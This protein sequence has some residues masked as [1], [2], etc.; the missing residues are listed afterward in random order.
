MYRDYANADAHVPGFYR[1]N[2]ERQTLEFARAK[3][4]RYGALNT[5]RMGIWGACETLDSL[6]DES[7]PDT[8]L[9]QIEHCLQTAEGIRRDGHPDGFVL[10]GLL[11]DLG[12]ILC[13]GCDGSA[14]STNTI[15]IPST[16]RRRTSTRCVRSTR[17]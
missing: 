11:H 3:R 16:T 10:A 1:L 9:T 8:G 4:E 5:T 17:I 12:K 6:V 15:S 13:D 14:G 7:D 2:H